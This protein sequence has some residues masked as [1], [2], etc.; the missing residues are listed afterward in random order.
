MLFNT[1]LQFEIKFSIKC[2]TRLKIYAIINSE[3][4]GNYFVD[5]IYCLLFV[6]EF[7]KKN[8]TRRAF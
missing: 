5:I 2:D 6:H 7:L 3:N 8:V 1:S 4:K